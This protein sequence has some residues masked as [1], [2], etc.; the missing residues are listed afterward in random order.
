MSPLRRRMIED[1]QIRNLSPHTQRAYVEQVVRFARHFRKSPEHLG[2]AEIRTYLLYLAQDKHLAASSIIVAVSALRFFYTVTLK[3]PLGCRGRHPHRPSGE[4]AARRA[5]PGRSGAVP[6]CRG[7]PEAPR[8]PDRLLRDR[9]ADLRSRPPH[10]RRDRQQ[11]H[12]HPGRAGQRPE[13]PLCHAAAQ[14]PRYAQGLLAGAPIP[15]SGCSRVTGLASRSRPLTI[16]HTCRAGEAAVR[17]RQAGHAAFP[18]PRLRRS[19]AGSG[20]RSAHH[21]VA[22]RSSQSEHHGAVSHDRHQ[23]GL[24]HGQSAGI[25]QRRCGQPRRTWCPPE[26]RVPWPARGWKWRMCSATSAR[27]FVTSMARRCPPRGG[28]P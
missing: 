2:P 13:R 25:T 8:D 20:H 4:E 18:A 24:R 23:Q 22:A 26:A 21:P 15:E 10:A 1:M 17:H 3:R 28:V 9:P 5:E 16:N 19:P 6:G 11:A 7:Q 12:G 27:L 14:T